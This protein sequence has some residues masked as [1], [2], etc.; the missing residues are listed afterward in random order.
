MLLI[1]L[2]GGASQ[3]GTWDPKPGTETGGPVRA[4]ETS[5]PGVRISELM[6][7]TA[8]QMHRIGLVR[9]VNTREDDHGKGGYLMR[10][11]TRRGPGRSTRTWARWCQGLEI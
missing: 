6:P 5:V 10:S 1:W 8:R 7:L 4:I 11:G 2:H 9:G 3:L